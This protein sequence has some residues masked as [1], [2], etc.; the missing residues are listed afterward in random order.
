MPYAELSLHI[1]CGYTTAG[2][3]SEKNS[4]SDFRH[5]TTENNTHV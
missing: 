2:G 5:G 3:H 1:R 4:V